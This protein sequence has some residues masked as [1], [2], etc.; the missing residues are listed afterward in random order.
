MTSAD[1]D[2]F[3]YVYVFVRRDIPVADQVCQAIHAGIEAGANFCNLGAK[4]HL[5]F[6]MVNDI[7]ELV[8]VEAI[9]QKRDV[10]YVIVDEPDDNLGLTAIATAP[11]GKKQGR[12][13]M[14]YSLWK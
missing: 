2:D 11:I 7:A 4:P 5:C 13:F 1:E 10:P 8:K 14:Q 12:C 9:C 3:V 6:L